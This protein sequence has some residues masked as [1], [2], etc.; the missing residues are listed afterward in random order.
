MFSGKLV[1]FGEKWFSSGIVIGIGQKRLYSCKRDCFRVKVDVFGQLCLY[2]AKWLFFRKKWLSSGKVVL[3]GQMWLYSDK[4]R[5]IR[6][7]WLYSGRSGCIRAKVVLFG[8]KV[9]FGQK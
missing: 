4:C 5:S 2:W 7:K 6:G 3:F 9:V 1:V 8:N